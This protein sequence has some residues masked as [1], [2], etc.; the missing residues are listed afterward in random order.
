MLDERP[1]DAGLV[2]R[3]APGLPDSTGLVGVHSPPG[4]YASAACAEPRPSATV[5][6]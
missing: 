3:R 1:P 4:G 2:Q 6:R 5:S